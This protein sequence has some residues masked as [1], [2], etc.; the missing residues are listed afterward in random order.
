MN[1][2]NEKR[3][4]DDRYS[5]IINFF[6]TLNV[7]ASPLLVSL[8]TIFFILN[9]W[10][11]M[12]LWVALFQ[13]LRYGIFAILG[14]IV[15]SGIDK[16]LKI[17]DTQMLGGGLK[18][19]ALLV[20]VMVAWLTSEAQIAVG[21]QLL[22][23]VAAAITASMLTA[24]I[25]KVLG[26]NNLP[27][28]VWGYCL[29]AVMLF[30]ICPTCTVL[31]NNVILLPQDTMDWT[32]AFFHS[33][34][35]LI[36]AQHYGVGLM[37]G[38]A[39]FL[40]SRIM[41][42][43]GVIGWL[44]GVCVTLAF[45]Q[46]HTYYW[47]PASY[48]Y[49]IAGMALGSVFFL[50]GWI[51]L[52]IAALGGCIAAFLG[53]VLQQAMPNSPIVYLPITAAASIWLV[54]IAA[55]FTRNNIIAWRNPT[56][57]LRPEE[58]WWQA[59]YWAQRFGHQEMLFSV[60]IV[61]EVRVSQGVNG[62]LSHVSDWCYALDFQ[63]PVT[64][65]NSLDPALNLWGAPVYAPASGIIDSS[66]T[67]IPDNQLGVCNYAENWGNYVII[68]LDQGG[69][70]LLAHMK[71][72]SIRCTIGERVEAGDYIGNVGNSGRSPIPHLHIQAQSTSV[73]GSPTVP[74]RMVNYY[75]KSD[76]DSSLDYWNAASLPSESEIILA[77][78]PNQIVHNILASIAPGSAVWVIESKGTIPR[79]F[80]EHHTNKIIRINT[81]LDK[82][83]QHLF[84]S[85]YKEGTLVACLVADAWR[86]IETRQVTSPFMK[87]LAL[88]VPSIP[89]CTNTGMKWRD[90]VPLMSTG[91]ASWVTMSIK[92]FTGKHFIF[93]NCKCSSAPSV[94]GDKLYIETTLESSGDSSL[95]LSLTCEF[96]ILR[97]PIKIQA[98]F[99]DG[100]VVYTLLSFEPRLPFANKNS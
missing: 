18:A 2:K 8:G 50:P 49:F 96:E 44:S 17:K 76:N 59:K 25:I 1:I 56:P 33:L 23:A 16:V 78:Y 65:D 28:L 84:E 7:F 19:N 10:I 68:S 29:T 71:Q 11:S 38:L 74:F 67:V 61:G 63:R 9:P 39:I 89:Y 88:A 54:M 48:N 66:S 90:P 37:V 35:T 91:P 13:N 42:V 98:N 94:D 45:E 27:S 47:L 62:S 31:V 77:A 72:H 85:N 80:R 97:G 87:L 60:P 83:G 92:P 32:L 5:N 58:S 79:N 51:S 22:V 86:I 75:S 46:L 20:A 21:A 3:E 24:G 40:W 100:T 4:S 43:A 34:G 55:S 15:A 81:T 73:L 93:S 95:P 57:R 52:L 82:S 36:Y 12:I 41:F 14:I 99:K 6:S 70:A 26:G 30:G 53:L 69:W 64:I